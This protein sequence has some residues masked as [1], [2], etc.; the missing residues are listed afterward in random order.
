MYGLLII[1]R[2]WLARLNFKHR[3]K[4]GAESA[5]NDDY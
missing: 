3:S 5:N 2:L 1:G 4:P